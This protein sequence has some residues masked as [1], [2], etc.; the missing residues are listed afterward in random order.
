MAVTVTLLRIFI[1]LL[2][3][4]FGTRGETICR[5]LLNLLSY[6]GIIVFVYFALYD[7][8]FSPG[9]LLASLGLL[10]F[11]VSLGAKDLV[12]DILAGLSIVFDGEYQV[13]DIIE[14]GGYRGEVLEIGV[15]TTKLE[16]RGGNIKITMGQ[17]DTDG[18]DSNGD[19]YITGG[20]ID[21]TGQSTCDYDGKAEKTGGTL[22]IN[23]EETDTIPNQMMGGHGGMGGPGGDMG[24]FRM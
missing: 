6:G 10:S 16:G 22:I 1:Q 9:T 11:A 14:V 18:I 21:I 17:G 20:T 12:T 19:L 7:L 5:L 8:G 24:G 2:S 23:G 15:R 3:N 4:A 13:G